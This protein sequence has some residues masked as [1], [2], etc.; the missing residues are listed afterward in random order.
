MALIW[1]DLYNLDSGPGLESRLCSLQHQLFLWLIHSVDQVL[2][3]NCFFVSASYA[4]PQ[5]IALYDESD[6]ACACLSK[7]FQFVHESRW[8]V[9]SFK[10]D[11]CSMNHV[12]WWPTYWF[13]CS[14][15]IRI[16]SELWLLELFSNQATPTRQ[17]PG[18]HSV[19][20]QTSVFASWGY[21]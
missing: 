1:W 13:W 8:H 14:D 16:F 7:L 12:F 5:T 4:L 10:Y 15:E 6:E 18:H 20:V 2:I 11:S 21:I 19:A 17:S 9:L 3:D